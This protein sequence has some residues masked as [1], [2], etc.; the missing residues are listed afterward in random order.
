MVKRH[1]ELCESNTTIFGVIFIIRQVIFNP[2]F[3]NLTNSGWISGWNQGSNSKSNS[4]LKFDF[5]LSQ[6]EQ[7]IINKLTDGNKLYLVDKQDSRIY[8]LEISISVPV[9]PGCWMLRL[10][11]NLNL[12]QPI[13]R[14]FWLQL[15]ALELYLHSLTDCFCLIHLN[16]T[17]SMPVLSKSAN[18]NVK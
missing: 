7:W 11:L 14:V 16:P 18:T 1:V 12:I 8:S 13:R 6:N 17:H 9:I 2:L 5:W 4:F 10:D 15:F 3:L